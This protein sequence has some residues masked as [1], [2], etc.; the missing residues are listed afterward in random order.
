MIKNYRLLQ[1]MVLLSLAALYVGCSHEEESHEENLQI[2][3]DCKRCIC[4]ATDYARFTRDEEGG[5]E[6]FEYRS[7]SAGRL[8]IKHR[9]AVFDCERFDVK[10]DI[11]V[12]GQQILITENAPEMRA[13]C[14][15]VYDIDY[16]VTGLSE[17]DY[18]VVVR[19]ESSYNPDRKFNI[20]YSKDLDDSYVL[21]RDY[22]IPEANWF[23]CEPKE[24]Y[25]TKVLEEY[26]I[27]ETTSTYSCFLVTKAP[28]AAWE[29]AWPYVGDTLLVEKHISGNTFMEG[30]AVQLTVKHA[31]RHFDFPHLWLIETE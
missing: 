15:G 1:M 31:K 30:D 12:T 26:Q 4:S 9:N 24:T 2:S 6:A 17:G 27:G 10:V 14:F 25:E 5:N 19:N 3:P 21:R 11:S 29:E 23:S 16:E 13:D 8:Y 28:D 18:S 20:H 22:G 7:L